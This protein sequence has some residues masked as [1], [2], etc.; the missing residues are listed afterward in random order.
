LILNRLSRDFGVM[1]SWLYG[2]RYFGLLGVWVCV[3]F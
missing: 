3:V 1:V 2:V